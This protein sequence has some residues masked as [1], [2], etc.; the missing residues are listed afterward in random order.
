MTTTTLKCVVK[1]MVSEI[2]NLRRS[3]IVSKLI[4]GVEF[5]TLLSLPILIP[6]GIIWLGT[7]G[8]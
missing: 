7:N 1:S 6:F 2:E 4:D 8:L 5:I 3:E